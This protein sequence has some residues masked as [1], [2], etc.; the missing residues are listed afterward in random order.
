M[1]SSL[2]ERLVSKV[3]QPSSFGNPFSP[4]LKENCFDPQVGPDGVSE[5]SDSSLEIA[6]AIVPEGQANRLFK[7]S[8]H[9][10]KLST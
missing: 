5:L 4:S 2:I 9:Y 3:W 6:A 8:H 7:A 1:Y 10:W